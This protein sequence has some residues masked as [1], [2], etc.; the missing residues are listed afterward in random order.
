MPCQAEAKKE[1]VFS[2]LQSCL[3]D[4]ASFTKSTQGYSL[5][6]SMKNFSPVLAIGEESEAEGYNR[7]LKI[8][9]WLCKQSR[10]SSPMEGIAAR[11]MHKLEL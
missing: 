3:S 8:D 2:V 9:S 11:H 10:R 4:N 5:A 1:F 7:C 6:S